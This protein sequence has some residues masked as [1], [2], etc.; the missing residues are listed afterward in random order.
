M[1]I[2]NRMLATAKALGETVWE[3]PPLILHPFN[4]H[5]SPAQLLENSR[6]ALMLSGLLPDSGEDHERLARKLMVGRYSEIRMLYF[7]GKDVFRWV[8]QCMEIADRAPGLSGAGVKRQSFAGLLAL[9]PRNVREKLIGWGVT[10]YSTVFARA[11][12]L[13]SIFAEPP[14]FEGISEDFIR[15]YHRVA[16]LLYRGFMESEPHRVLAAR[17]F[18]FELYASGEYAKRLESEWNE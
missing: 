16:D 2:K 11:V 6:A 7:L 12:G 18:Q 4:E 1:F 5:T 9:P 15:N 3:L 8:G 17:N 13:N 14:A 10:D